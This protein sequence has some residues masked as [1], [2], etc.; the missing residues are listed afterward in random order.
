MYIRFFRVSQKKWA[1]SDPKW[2]RPSERTWMAQS[3]PKWPKIP[4]SH[5]S[6]QNFKSTFFLGH[7]VFL[8]PATPESVDCSPVAGALGRRQTQLTCLARSLVAPHIPIFITKQHSHCVSKYF[9]RGVSLNLVSRCLSNVHEI[10]HGA[11][12]AVRVNKS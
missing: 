9:P 5:H 1:Q 8:R 4:A 12:S 2:P 10:T 11:L 3:G 7:P 6:P